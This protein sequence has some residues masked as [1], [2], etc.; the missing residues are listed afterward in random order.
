MPVGVF[1]PS[2]PGD[3]NRLN[4]LDLGRSM[5]REYNKEFLGDPEMRGT[6]APID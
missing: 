1:Q 5:A 4:D 6:T 3:R 2:S